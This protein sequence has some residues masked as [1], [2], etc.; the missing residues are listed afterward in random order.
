M[1][2]LT[3][4]SRLAIHSMNLSADRPTPLRWR[5]FWLAT[6]FGFVLL[7]VYLS[8]TP[9]PP[10]L[11]I[12]QGLKFGHV[13]AYAWLMLWF[14]QLYRSNYHRCLLVAA[15]CILGIALEYVQGMTDYRGFEYSDMLINSAGV[16]IG[17]VFALTRLQNTLS[18]LEQQLLRE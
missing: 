18:W 8:L 5:R 9:D 14:A 15:F 1:A 4:S 13:L 16:A 6:G 11:G 3:D 12:P 7:V 2:R 17:W 10:D